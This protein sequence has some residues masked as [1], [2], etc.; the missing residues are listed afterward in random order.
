MKALNNYQCKGQISMFDWLSQDTQFMKTYPEHSVPTV[1]KISDVSL[2]KPVKL[3]T[4][5]PMFLDLRRGKDGLMPDVSWVTDIQLLGESMMQG[6]MEYHKEEKDYVFSLI[7]G[8]VQHQRYYLN[9][10]EKPM[11]P[12]PSKLSQILENNPNPKYNLSAKACQGILNRA[13]K[14]GKVLPE[15]L[16]IVLEKQAGGGIRTFDVRISSEG[17]KNQRAHCYETDRSRALD[18]GG[19]NP[20]S[21]HGGIAVIE[22][23]T[24]DKKMGNTYV[25]CEEANTL[26]ARDFKQPQATV[27]ENRG[28]QLTSDNVVGCDQYNQTTT[29]D[30]SKTLNSVKSDSDHVPCVCY[31]I[32]AYDSNSMKSS[33][34]HSGIYEADTS[35]TLDLNGGSPACNQGGMAIVENVAYGLDRASFNQGKNAKFGFSV[36]EELAPP[37]IAKGPGGG[38]SQT[39]GALCARDYKGVGN[40]YVDEGKCIIQQING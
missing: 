5:T 40:Q 16:R 3:Q 31:G 11:I 25:H 24:I 15:L 1:E 26:G 38:I 30:V 13:K 32:S 23:W 9:L 10:S 35:R 28:Q 6:G 34:P 29:G 36:D 7:M 37:L 2:K 18:T 17:T 27:V 20:D 39:V 14:R 22:H 4:K 21:N 12:K 19:E 33:N 8:G